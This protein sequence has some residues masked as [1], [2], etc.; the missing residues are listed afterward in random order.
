M[1][2]NDKAGVYYAMLFNGVSLKLEKLHFSVRGQ[3][4]QDM[5]QADYKAPIQKFQAITAFI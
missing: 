2:H 1:T 3:F 4:V 5:A